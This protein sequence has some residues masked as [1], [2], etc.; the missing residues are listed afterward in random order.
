MSSDDEDSG[1]RDIDA[2]EKKLKH[3][4]GTILE[5]SGSSSDEQIQEAP[6]SAY[7]ND[8]VKL[9]TKVKLLV[10]QVVDKEKEIDSLR[11]VLGYAK[12]EPEEYEYGG[13]FRDQKLM[14][15]AKKV[16]T[17]QVALESE[18]NRA[19]R[20]ME[21]VNRLREDAMKKENTKGW[22]KNAVKEDASERKIQGLEKSLQELQAKHMSTKADLKKAKNLL[23][24]EVGEFEN[25]DA[26][27]KNETWKGRAQQIE[28]LKSRINDLK[29]QIGKKTEEP[30]M[31]AQN[32]IRVEG[33]ADERRKEILGLQEQLNK[34]KEELDK[35]KK[36]SQ[37][38]SSRLVALEK[39]NKEIRET[40]KVQIKTLLDKTENDDK[41]IAELKNEIE[42]LR[43]SKGYARLEPISNN[44]KE[45]A[46]LK[47]QIANLHQT[48][49]QM[50]Q[51]LDEKNKIIEMFKNVGEEDDMQ[52]EVEYKQ[53]IQNL[54]GE[55]KRL[56]DTEKK[57]ANSEDAK[58]IKDLSSQN[59]RL[60]NKVNELTEELGK[61]R[62]PKEN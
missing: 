53:K 30:P 45:A 34:T 10:Q 35:H 12:P 42:R 7:S 32:T 9:Q 22:S 44:N 31:T 58:L 50:Q 1:M 43:K 39:E 20:A 15:L 48:L 24:R 59:A 49:H 51:E 57:S 27:S 13:D 11:S 8:N 17:L 36:K 61:Y 29:R 16:R 55:I 18:K 2:F 62:K 37:G 21:E 47:W 6:F 4:R 23:K 28:L 54:E 40:H 33:T 52:N 25:L 56:K 3:H 26:L 19:A 14:E 60:R 38:Y 46:E 5:E 41:F